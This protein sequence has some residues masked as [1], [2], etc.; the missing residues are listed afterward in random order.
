[1]GN[2]GKIGKIRIKIEVFISGWPEMVLIEIQFSLHPLEIA[3]IGNMEN[4]LQDNLFYQF[5]NL[6]PFKWQVGE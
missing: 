4:L 2:V 1:M 3:H 6:K 5:S